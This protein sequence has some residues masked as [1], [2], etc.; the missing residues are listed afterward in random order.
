M[1]HTNLG[2]LSLVICC[3]SLQQR[4][5]LFP[6]TSVHFYERETHSPSDLMGNL[7][8]FWQMALWNHPYDKN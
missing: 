6:L 2:S 7:N 4:E 8:S 3:D 1:L 5:V